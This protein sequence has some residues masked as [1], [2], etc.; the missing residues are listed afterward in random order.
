[1]KKGFFVILWSLAVL[2]VFP[3]GA[4]PALGTAVQ[5]LAADSQLKHATFGFYVVDQQSGKVLYDHLGETGL[6]PASCQKVITS[7]AALDL[8]GPAYR[9]QTTLS[10]AG[11]VHGSI[12]SGDLIIAGSGDP[13][14]GSPRWAYTKESSVLPVWISEVKKAGIKNITGSIYAD[15][16]GWGTTTIPD[17][18]IWQD[19]GNYYGAGAS[20]LNWRENQY[21]V[22]LKSGRQIGDTCTIV[23]LNPPLPGISLVSEVLTAARGT[24]DHAFIYLPP[25]ATSGVIRGTIPAGETAFSISGSLPDPGQQ[26]GNELAASLSRSGIPVS[27]ENQNKRA[28]GDNSTMLSTILSP[29][30]DSIN[31]WFLK[32]SVNLYGEALV[33][34]IGFKNGGEATTEKGVGIVQYFWS[35]RGVEKS[36]I[37]IIDGSGLSPQNR[38]TAHALVTVMQYARTRPWFNAFQQALPEINGIM[39]KSGSIGGARSYTG[40]ISAKDGKAYTFAFIINNYDG[41]ASEIQRK[42]WKVLDVL[43]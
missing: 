8:L 3:Q 21:D 29:P 7:V 40:Y 18:W 25:Q 27:F 2:D 11:T 13:T 28:A 6:A 19:M 5:K 30:L 32:K 15:P 20:V 1:M 17:G 22:R 24:G 35:K 37:Q 26:L 33:K 9:F 34:T 42:M 12:L 43:K 14:L 16:G 31:Y 38:V 36:S 41:S 39:M 4:W 10:Y 23:S